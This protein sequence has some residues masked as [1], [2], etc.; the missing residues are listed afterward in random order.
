[1]ILSKPLGI[2]QAERNWKCYKRNKSGQRAKLS[3]E[4]VKKQVIITY[5][6]RHVKSASRCTKIQG[7]G[8]VCEEDDFKWLKMNSYC[9]GSIINQINDQH[10]WIFEC[11]MEPWEK[12]K[13]NSMGVNC[14]SDDLHAA[15]I[16]AKYGGIKY[17]D[18]DY[19]R[20]GE[21]QKHNCVVWKKIDKGSSTKQ[22][23]RFG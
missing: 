20:V 19:H 17:E 8:K 4:R 23:K 11:Y 18:E 9:I 1:M 7:T 14:K 2:G 16:S 10:V 12:V 22:E 5:S 21:L 13:F 3:T 15:R 6:Y